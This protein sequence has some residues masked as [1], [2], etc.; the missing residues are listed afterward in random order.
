M[1]NYTIQ[2]KTI[3]YTIQYYT[4]QFS[5][6]CTQCN[7]MIYSL[8]CTVHY[9]TLYYSVLTVLY[10]IQDY[11]KVHLSTLHFTSPTRQTVAVLARCS[12]SR[13]IF[14]IVTSWRCV[15]TAPVAR[16]GLA[17]KTVRITPGKYG[18][19]FQGNTSTCE[20]TSEIAQYNNF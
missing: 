3:L 20:D 2:Y 15:P 10:R 5:L 13:P 1:Q 11:T 14:A 7:H 19:H 8:N 16:L 6:Y 17:D 12:I 18:E 9:T 4:I